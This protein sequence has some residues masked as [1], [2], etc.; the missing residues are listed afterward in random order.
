MSSFGN[1]VCLHLPV[2]NGVLHV[3]CNLIHHWKVARALARSDYESVF[4]FPFDFLLQ[5]ED[6]SNVTDDS[7]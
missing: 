1:S 7:C 6:E 5:I 3:I 4:V 2:E